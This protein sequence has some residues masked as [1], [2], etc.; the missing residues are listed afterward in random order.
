ML[1]SSL[2]KQS[3]KTSGCAY[4]F[5]CVDNYISYFKAVARCLQPSKKV[6]KVTNLA[7]S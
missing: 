2:Y 6:E 1:K 4:C 3:M 7:N 5:Y